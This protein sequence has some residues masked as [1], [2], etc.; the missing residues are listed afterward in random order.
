MTRTTRCPWGRP[1][2]DQTG[3]VTPSVDQKGKW[4]HLTGLGK[5]GGATWPTDLV[6]GV[7]EPAEH[8]F[9]TQKGADVIRVPALH[10]HTPAPRRG[11]SGFT[12]RCLF[13]GVFVLPAA[14][15]DRTSGEGV[16]M[17]T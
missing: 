4:P 3:T 1:E 13:G 11:V 6:R 17:V 16:G 7:R 8:P 14:S 2:S 5:P 15:P 10:A 9:S 12:C